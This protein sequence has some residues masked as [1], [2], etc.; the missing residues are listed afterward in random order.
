MPDRHAADDYT[1]KLLPDAAEQFADLL[2]Q[3]RS[4]GVAEI[5]ILPAPDG[6]RAALAQCEATYP[7]DSIPRLPFPGC[8]RSPCC[9]C[10][11]LPVLE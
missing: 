8:D 11:Y 7:I 1:G 5:Q 3:Y 4:M 2:H 9:A 6:C 10:D